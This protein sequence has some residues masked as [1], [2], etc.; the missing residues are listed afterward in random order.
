MYFETTDFWV[1]KFGQGDCILLDTL[2]STS[3]HS[4]SRHFDQYSR[5]LNHFKSDLGEVKSAAEKFDK[6]GSRADLTMS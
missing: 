5:D 1:A 4:W 3:S 2:A 6:K